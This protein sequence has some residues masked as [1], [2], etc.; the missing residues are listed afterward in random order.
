MSFIR[1][2]SSAGAWCSLRPEIFS[3]GVELLGQ[4]AED[5]PIIISHQQ[6]FGRL[7]SEPTHCL[8][9]TQ[10]QNGAVISLYKHVQHHLSPLFWNPANGEQ[11]RRGQFVAEFLCSLP[12]DGIF[13]RFAFLDATTEQGPWSGNVGASFV[14]CWSNILPSPSYKISTDTC[15]WTSALR[16]ISSS[17]SP[18]TE[19][20]SIGGN[21]G[22]RC[23]QPLIKCP[24]F[25]G[26]YSV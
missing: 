7:K 26:H 21:H 20:G 9:F 8:P 24:R 17:S 12:L 1:F 14:R 25:S 22:V 2:S 11:T 4:E 5:G 13:G 19:H 6:I 16:F 23:R 10:C 3:V 15:F 18:S